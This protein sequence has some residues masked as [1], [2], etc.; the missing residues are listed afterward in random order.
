MSVGM[1]AGAGGA[2][3]KPNVAMKAAPVST[4]EARNEHHNAASVLP[5][6]DEL[7]DADASRVVT[8]VA[9]MLNDS[10]QWTQKRLRFT[11]HSD[12]ERLMVLVLDAQTDEVLRE[13]PP[14]DMLNLVARVREFI[15]LL[16][17]ELA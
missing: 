11:I 13:L 7:H 17:D 16:F 2:A 15:G 8:E 1:M 6:Q 5:A 14:E 10:A 12:T 3:Y 4:P 9:E